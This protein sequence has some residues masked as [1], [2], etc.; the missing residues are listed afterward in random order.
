MSEVDCSRN[1]PS[2]NGEPLRAEQGWKQKKHVMSEA[3]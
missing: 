3:E 1:M 2:I